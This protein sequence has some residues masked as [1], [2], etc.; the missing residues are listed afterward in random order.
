M[1]AE[2]LYIYIYI[3]IFKAVNSIDKCDQYFLIMLDK[4]FEIY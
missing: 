1:F 4:V 3:Y 2:K